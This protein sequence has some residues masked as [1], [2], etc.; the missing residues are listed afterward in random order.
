MAE[1]A[2]LA[3]I[4]LPITGVNIVNSMSGLQRWAER[5]L[6]HAFLGMSALGIYAFFNWVALTLMTLTGSMIQALQPHLYDVMSRS[7]NE[8][9][10]EAYLLRPMWTLTVGG[11]LLFGLCA[12]IL[13]DLVAAFLAPYALGIPVMQCLLFA[14][15]LNCVYWVPAV[16]IYAV[17]FNG[18]FYYFLACSAGVLLSIISAAALLYAGVDAIAVAIGFTLSQAL[19]GTLTFARLWQYLFP[20]PRVALRFFSSLI[21]PLLNVSIAIIGIHIFSS[22]LSPLPAPWLAHLLAASGKG[23]AFLSISIPAIVLLER[24]TG[25]Y[26]EHMQPFLAR[27]RS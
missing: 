27:L 18:Q 10:I 3:G 17:R 25:I 23:V 24:K 9:E 14:A 4:G 8:K 7:L 20:A 12:A 2:R 1:F 26:R 5:L 11:L 22:L 21:I 15:Y 19:V 13:P 16:M 6:I